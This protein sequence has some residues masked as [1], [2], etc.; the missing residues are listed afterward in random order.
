MLLEL[1]S[2]PQ[3]IMDSGVEQSDEPRYLPTRKPEDGAIDWHLTKREIYNFIRALTSPYP[4]AF[5]YWNDVKII[6]YKAI[7]FDVP[8]DF[9]RFLIGEIC[10]VY[11][12]TKNFV[13]R[14]SDGFILVRQWLSDKDW[15]PEEGMI[16]KSADFKKQI[17]EI[18]ERWYKQNPNLI[19]NE[20]ILKIMQQHG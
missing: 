9:E 7:P 17:R 3:K 8:I 2:D 14:C 15:T 4:G 1:L 10:V 16:L 19:L 5:T 20:N 13:V 18:V 6:I 12:S 11:A